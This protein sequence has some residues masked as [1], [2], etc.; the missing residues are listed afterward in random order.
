MFLP[1]FELLFLKPISSKGE[2]TATTSASWTLEDD[3][4]RSFR[5]LLLDTLIAD[6]ISLRGGFDKNRPEISISLSRRSERNDGLNREGV[7]EKLGFEA[8]IEKIK[9]GNCWLDRWRV[10]LFK[11]TFCI[12]DRLK[13]IYIYIYYTPSLVQF[14]CSLHL[15]VFRKRVSRFKRNRSIIGQF[16]LKLRAGLRKFHQTRAIK[17]PACSI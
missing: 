17:D 2:T 15:Q 9:R 13:N 4:Y 12:F 1:A 10:K 3:G 11:F 8:K 7:R 6:W 16:A 14:Y 5:R